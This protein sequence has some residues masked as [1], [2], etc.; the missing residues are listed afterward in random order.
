MW[1]NAALAAT[2]AIT[3]K[4]ALAVG[5]TAVAAGMTAATMGIDPWPWVISAG[6][7]TVAY[8]Y[9]NPDSRKK[10]LSNGLISVFLGGLAAPWAGALI[11]L[12]VGAEWAN[13][14]VLAGL[15]SAGWPWAAPP[16]LQFAQRWLGSKGGS[17][18]P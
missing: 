17:N 2:L 8:S 9:L 11:E 6:G 12:K 16:L 4:K 18:A 5:A 14:Y 13:Q 7:A 1:K 10:A 3:A 15:F